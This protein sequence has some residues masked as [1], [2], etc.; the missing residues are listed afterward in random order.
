MTSP[1]S[2][3]TPRRRSSSAST[4]HASPWA[5]SSTSTSSAPSTSTATI[6]GIFPGWQR[7]GGWY[8]F[9]PRDRK[10]GCGGRPSR[11]TE[12]GFWK[13]T[14]SDRAIRSTADPK[15]VIGIKKTLVFYKGRTETR[16]TG[17]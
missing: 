13:A 7:S 10:A 1:A 17:S 8:F 6:P 14:G 5:R 15:R 11:T 9:V 2:G 4:S 12:R 16:R 3:S